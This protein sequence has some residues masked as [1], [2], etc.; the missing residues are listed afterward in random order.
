MEYI[1]PEGLRAY[2]DVYQGQFSRK[3]A[4]WAVSKMKSRR[5]SGEL[6]SVKPIPVETVMDALKE[7]G[8]HVSEECTY[9][10]WYLWHM[11]VADYPRTIEKDNRRAWFVDET[12]NDP[13]GKA[14]NVLAC[15][16]AKMDNSGVAILWERMI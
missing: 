2:M 1:M 5:G 3:L 13:D 9:T 7:A 4:E 15:F 12:I 16:R 8:V 10:A 14:S 11:A 6:V